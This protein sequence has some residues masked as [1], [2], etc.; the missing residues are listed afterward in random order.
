MARRES[1]TRNPPRP[2]PKPAK[3][4]ILTE[5]LTPKPT[6]QILNAIEPLALGR[7]LRTPKPKALNLH[8]ELTP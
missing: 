7:K 2:T 1:R 8:P 6:L 3:D 5:T 4:L